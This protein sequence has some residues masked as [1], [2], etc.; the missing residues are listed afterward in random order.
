M[1]WVQL[2]SAKYLYNYNTDISSAW[3]NLTY[4]IKYREKARHYSADHI[5]LTVTA[6][7]DILFWS[8][9]LTCVTIVHVV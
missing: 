7:I 6:I 5:N 9:V 1:T 3:K 4:I 2:A 8:T